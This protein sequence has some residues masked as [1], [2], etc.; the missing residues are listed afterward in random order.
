MNNLLL[1]KPGQNVGGSSKTPTD[2][3]LQTPSLLQTATLF[4][5]FY[6]GKFPPKHKPQPTI[7]T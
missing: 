2:K 6:H 7:C 4:Q 1:L 3:L 5:V